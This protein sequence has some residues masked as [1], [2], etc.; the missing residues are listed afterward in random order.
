MSARCRCVICHKELRSSTEQER[1]K[2]NSCINKKQNASSVL[3]SVAFVA[4][5]AAIG[6][7]GG[8]VA[9][10]WNNDKNNTSKSNEETKENDEIDTTMY[11]PDDDIGSCPICYDK[12]VNVALS[13]C[14]HTLCKD[15]TDQLP[16]KICPM[17]SKNIKSQQTIYIN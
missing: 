12:R 9:S 1:R 10:L 2:C 5:G 14:G 3:T 4:V 8:Y 17:C 13:P 6:F 7:V 11:N 16:N 15:C